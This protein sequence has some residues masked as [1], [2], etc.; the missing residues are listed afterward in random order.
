MSNSDNIIFS[1]RS[2]DNCSL[3]PSL[4]ITMRRRTE[5]KNGVVL[6]FLEK[7]SGKK[8]VSRQSSNRLV[9]NQ[10]SLKLRSSL[11]VKHFDGLRRPILKT[12]FEILW[13][14]AFLGSAS[15]IILIPV[16][17]RT[18]DAINPTSFWSYYFS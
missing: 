4:F 12:L 11:L 5:R 15:G 1:S 9:S 8:N 17:S 18:L 6:L 14:S 16:Q 2:V 10:S 13:L 3:K 7:L